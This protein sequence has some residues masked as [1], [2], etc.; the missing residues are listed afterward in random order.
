MRLLLAAVAL[1]LGS[2]S[3]GYVPIGDGGG[4]KQ[5]CP[6]SWSITGVDEWIQGETTLDAGALTM[7]FFFSQRCAPLVIGP[8]R[9][10]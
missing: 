7:V 4:K 3:G 10:H 5:T 6:E 8:P 2:V 1:L 9:R